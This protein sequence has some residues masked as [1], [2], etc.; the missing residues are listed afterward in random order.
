MKARDAL[1]RDVLR[2]LLAAAK[3]QRVEQKTALLSEAELVQL[4]RKEIRKREEAEEFAA[5]AG[6][7]DLV[8]RNAAERA[9]LE[10]YL[11]APLDAAAL[12][13]VVRELAAEPGATLSGV[14][15]ALKTR[16]AGR[17]DGRLASELA[18]RALGATATARGSGT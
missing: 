2:G 5:R 18:R 1:R 7:E 8:A 13:A 12:E 6:R 16:W 9:I 4:V 14:M 10:A 3:H 17:Y 11:P 15:S